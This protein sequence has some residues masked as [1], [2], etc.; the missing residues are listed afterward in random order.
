LRAGGAD[1][2]RD[3]VAFFGDTRRANVRACR[4]PDRPPL[5]RA[6]PLSHESG[7]VAR[8]EAIAGA[9]AEEAERALRADNA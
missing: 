3:G 7:M 2:L 4:L 5:R 8:G 1:I 9:E 6:R